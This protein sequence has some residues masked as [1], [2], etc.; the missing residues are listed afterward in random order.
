MDVHDLKISIHNPKPG[1]TTITGGKISTLIMG[2]TCS[3]KILEIEVIPLL[4][5]PRPPTTLSKHA[6]GTVILLKI[7]KLVFSH[8]IKIESYREVGANLQKI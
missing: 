4:L 1:I 5:D 7:D 3:P 6:R 8:I 2:D